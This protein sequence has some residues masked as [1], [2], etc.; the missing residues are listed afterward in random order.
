MQLCIA[1]IGNF[2]INEPER[3]NPCERIVNDKTLLTAIEK[4][5]NTI[6]V[7]DIVIVEDPDTIDKPTLY[8][9]F[10]FPYPEC[11][12]LMEDYVIFDITNDIPMYEE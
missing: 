4:R 8:A 5:L 3:I 7:K 11:M 12:A 2:E 10:N 1:G 6:T 9:S